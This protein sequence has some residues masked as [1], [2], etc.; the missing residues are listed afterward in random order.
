MWD[1]REKETELAPN[2]TTFPKDTAR[3]MQSISLAS[4]VKFINYYDFYLGKR[5]KQFKS[6]SQL[7]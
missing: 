6:N 2:P 4:L 1:A 5:K 7:D 3:E